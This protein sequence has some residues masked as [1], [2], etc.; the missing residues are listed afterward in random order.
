MAKGNMFLSQARGKVGSV[1]FSV[2]KGQQVERVYN[3]SPANPRTNGQQA[4]RS[5]LAN[6]TKFYK[7]G[8]KNFF[9]FAFE[10][11]TIRES[12]FNAFARKNI[13]NGAYVPREFFDNENYPALGIYTMT[14]GSIAHNVQVLF[15]GDYIIID[16]GTNNLT[17][18]AATVTIGQVSAAILANNPGLQQGDLLTFVSADSSMDI[19]MEVGSDIPTWNIIQFYLDP[20]DTSTV[21]SKGFDFMRAQAIGVGA[22]RG[23]L[24]LQLAGIDRT[25]FAALCFSRKTESGLMVSTSTLRPSAVAE[26]L[27]YWLR[28]EYAK[29][30]AAASWGGNPDA[31]LEGGLL[32]NLPQ[33][34]KVNLGT[35]VDQSPYAYASMLLGGTGTARLLAFYGDNL[36]TT[37]QGGSWKVDFFSAENDLEDVGGY[38]PTTHTEVALT[39]TTQTSGNVTFYNAELAVDTPTWT[40]GYFVISYNG[41]PFSYG[42]M[43]QSV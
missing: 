13:M 42:T 15:N 31:V 23:I 3:P 8:S 1:V 35:A 2:I 11:K 12:D 20:S 18:T 5:L 33:I 24:F 34:S 10:D 29:Q 16:P 43:I 14:A 21:A 39:V 30:V 41:V 25:S 37:A 38:H 4:Q 19:Q 7:R 32:S 28:G 36:R 26:C 27:V 6:M 9:K 22:E 17:G 40:Q